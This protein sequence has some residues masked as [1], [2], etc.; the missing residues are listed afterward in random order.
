MPHF[1]RRLFVRTAA[2]FAALAP[3]A[4]GRS[5]FADSLAAG[6]EIITGTGDQKYRVEHDWLTPPTGVVWGD[7]HGLAQDAAGRIYVSHT[8]HPSSTVKHAIVVFDRSGKPLTSW[9]E[10]FEGGGH[11]LDIRKEGDAEFL[12]HCDVNHR[13]L[14]KTTLDGELLWETGAPLHAKVGDQTCY[15]HENAWNPT[16]V[17]FAP[18]GDLFVGDGYGKSF[19]HRFS[20]DGEWKATIT[21][22]GAGKGE[23]S[24]PHGLWIDARGAAGAPSKEPVLAVADRGNRRIQYFSLE[25]KH[26][27]FVTDGMRQPCHFK[28]RGELLLVP[29]LSSVVTILDGDNKVVASL[30]D[31]DPS[32]LRGAPRE[33]FIPGKF[34]HPHTAMWLDDGSILVA[35]WVPIGRITRLVKV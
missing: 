22:P 13:R 14:A 1:S 30:C 8:V 16:N 7:T 31:S 18:D 3:A 15:D 27:S 20:K 29:D 28:T 6:G 5:G 9:G 19:V 25:G 35:E 33:Q 17:A 4:F 23:T 2:G 10:R 26:L 34:I 12:Y 32:N 24:C 11:G 21:T